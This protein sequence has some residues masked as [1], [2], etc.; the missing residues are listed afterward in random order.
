[1]SKSTS[2]NKNGF[3]PFANGRWQRLPQSTK[4]GSPPLLM[5]D[6]KVYYSQQE[7]V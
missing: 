3:K 2:V 7:W 6:V 1:M 4:T 5:V